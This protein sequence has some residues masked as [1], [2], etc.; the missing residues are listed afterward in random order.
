MEEVEGLP[1]RR[2]RKDMKEV[3]L[4]VAQKEEQVAADEEA[5]ADL[6]ASVVRSKETFSNSHLS[7]SSTNP[8]KR[9]SVQPKRSVSTGAQSTWGF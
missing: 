2:K 7:C 6:N 5:A 4:V 3:L 8:A 1:T 9:K